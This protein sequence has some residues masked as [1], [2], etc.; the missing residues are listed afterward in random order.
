MDE[1]TQQNAALVEEAAASSEAMN[2]QAAALDELIGFFKVGENTRR[3]EAPAPQRA[4][5]PAATARPAS[6]R[7]SAPKDSGGSEWEEF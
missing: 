5:R 4:A 6:A 2:D 1:M 7:R 3:A